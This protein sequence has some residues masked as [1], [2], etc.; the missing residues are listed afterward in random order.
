VF[1]AFCLV[2]SRNFGPG[3][4]LLALSEWF[5]RFLWVIL[6][7]L[8]VR[9]T[10]GLAGYKASV[11]SLVFFLFGLFVVWLC[12]LL[13]APSLVP[14]SLCSSCSGGCLLFPLAALPPVP[15]PSHRLIVVLL[16]GSVG[17]S[18]WCLPSGIWLF[19]ATARVYF[20][21]LGPS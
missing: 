1:S 15:A 5:L 13:V 2:I 10:R 12:F 9:V 21:L 17:L 4:P 11:L 8:S 14:R 18:C 3:Q 20:C 7:F 19:S 6:R 16:R